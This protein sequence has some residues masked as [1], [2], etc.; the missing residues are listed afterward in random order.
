MNEDT[1]SMTPR[2]NWMRMGIAAGVGVASGFAAMHFLGG[3]RRERV[4]SFAAGGLGG[5]GVTR[6][7]QS[8]IPAQ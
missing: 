8:F 1:S 5:Y 6:I 4:L 7:V 2:V 3:N